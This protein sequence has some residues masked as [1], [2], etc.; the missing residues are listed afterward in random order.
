MLPC[1][2]A[3]AVQYSTVCALGLQ[4][5]RLM[6]ELTVV[7]LNGDVFGRQLVLTSHADDQRTSSPA[8]TRRKRAA[9]ERREKER[10]VV[11][12]QQCLVQVLHILTYLDVAQFMFSLMQPI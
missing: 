3:H 11:I 9:A 7:V 5:Q 8:R 1:A 2:H 12:T 4:C 10:E 6:A